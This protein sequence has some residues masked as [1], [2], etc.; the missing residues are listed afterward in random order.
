MAYAAML[1]PTTHLQPAFFDLPDGRWSSAM[2]SES[3]PNMPWCFQHD[4][5]IDAIRFEVRNTPD[6][7]GPAD[8]ST[9]RRSEISTLDDPPRQAHNG[10]EQ[11]YAELVR[12]QPFDHVAMAAATTSGISLNQLKKD[13]DSPVF[14]IRMMPNGYL[15]VTKSGNYDNVK[16]F[17]GSATLGGY[18]PDGQPH[19]F[20]WMVKP[21]MVGG[22]AKLW[23]D[24]IQRVN[25]TG[26]IGDDTGYGPSFGIYSAGGIS[27]TLIAEYAHRTI[28]STDSLEAQATQIPSWPTATWHCPN[29]GFDLGVP[30]P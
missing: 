12:V 3:T 9:K 30:A 4:P 21:N 22:Q 13:G 19:W 14:A 6:D 1:D 28:L 11:W 23:M 27:E 20:V 15:R 5:D 10:V 8:P 25:Y 17:T 16:L 26:D 24:G 2:G 29:C 7:N 18:I